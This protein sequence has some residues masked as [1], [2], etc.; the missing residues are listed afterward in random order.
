MDIKRLPENHFYFS[1]ESVT[2]GHPDKICDSISDCILDACLSS[3]PNAKVACETVAKSN[4]ILI[5]GEIT[6]TSNFNEE[7]IIRD[8]LREIGYNDEKK[9]INY[10]SCDVIK[11]ITKQSPDIHQAV[12]ENKKDEDIGAG[13]QGLMFGYATN[14]TEEYMPFS[15]LMATK[16]AEKLTEVRKNKTLPWLR[17][18]GKTEVT[19]EYEK[20]NNGEVIPIRIENILISAQH[21]P[22]VQNEEIKNKIIENV[23]NTVIPKDK[24]DSNTRILINPSGKF[25]I[26]GPEGDCGLTGRK[27]IVDTYG[28]WG[29]HGG[30]AFSGKDCSKV[31]RSGAYLARWIAKS[32]VAEKLCKRCL[33]QISYS[34]GISDPLSVFVDSYGTVIEG[35]SDEQLAEIA[36]K[37][38][39]MKPGKIIQ[40]LKLNRPIFKKTSTGGHFGRNDP[41]FLWEVPKKLEY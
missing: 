24:I 16:L 40:D 32:L 39:N 28:G 35:K 9:G 14:E 12:S 30:G 22:D 8:R 20:K 13:D 11:K 29:G 31:D 27:I 5:A 19:V 2:E 26:G 1:S 33:V 10:E 6:T 23:I 25:I 4:M 37:N 3:D 15:F 18:D 7:Q 21:D 38:F 41:D 36:I 34:I 17:P